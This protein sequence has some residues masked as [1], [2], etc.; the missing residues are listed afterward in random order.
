MCDPVIEFEEES[1]S[2]PWVVCPTCECIN[3]HLVYMKQ[4]D[5]QDSYKAGWGGRGDLHVLGFEGEC[6]HDFEVCF[7]FHK[8]ITSVF[9]R[10]L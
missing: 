2:N 10:G 7:G 1:D 3:V 5:G 6:G 8:G 4:V 9:R